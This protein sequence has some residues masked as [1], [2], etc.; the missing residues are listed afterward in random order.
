MSLRIQYILYI[1]ILHL[2]AL[3]VSFLIF[4]TNRIWFIASELLLLLSLLFAIILYHKLVQPLQYLSQGVHAIR[5]RDFNVKF[6]E[7]GQLETDRLVRVYNDM[8][9][10][11]RQERT[12]QQQQHFFLDKLIR[13]SPVGI[14]IL[15]FDGRISDLNERAEHFLG[16]S[17]KDLQG[18]RPADYDHPLAQALQQLEVQRPQVIETNGMDTYKCQKAHFIDRGFPHHFIMIEELTAEKLRI[19]KQAYGKVIRMMSHE[20]NNSV[21]PVNSIL[22]SLLVYEQELPAPEHEPFRNA[23]LVARDRNERLNRFM[24]NFADVI[25]LPDPVR[26]LQDI[27]SLVSDTAKLMSYQTGERR[28]EWEVQ[29]PKTPIRVAFDRQQMEQVLINV[30]KN[31]IEAIPEQGTI[32]LVLDRNQL[33]IQDNGEGLTAAQA[34][35]LFSPFYSTKTKGQGIGLTISREILLLHGFSFSLRPAPPGWTCFTIK[36]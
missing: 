1:A 27:R 5:D 8:I 7:T 34:D 36:F 3:G 19:E 32:R 26:S 25:R 11:L 31:A 4:D 35:Q 28:I 12:L 14:V 2:T 16:A 18:K 20:V 10:Q 33:L 9:D 13:T 6:Q 17:L 15:D 22:E 29:L 24:R 30:L 23:I 21:G